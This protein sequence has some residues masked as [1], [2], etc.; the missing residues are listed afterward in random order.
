MTW[1]LSG[2]LGALVLFSVLL[3]MRV[4]CV[5]S[6]AVRAPFPKPV[7]LKALEAR[8]WITLWWAPPA[9]Q[10]PSAPPLPAGRPAD[11]RLRPNVQR[12]GQRQREK[13]VDAQPLDRVDQISRFEVFLVRLDNPRERVVPVRLPIE[14]QSHTFMPL[15]DRSLLLICTNE[16]LY[17]PLI[18]RLIVLYGTAVKNKRYAVSVRMC[19]ETECGEN[20]TDVLATTNTSKSRDSG[21][22]SADYESGGATSGGSSD[23]RL[24]ISKWNHHL[25][26]YTSNNESVTGHSVLISW[27][28]S[29]A[30]SEQP[31]DRFY[32][33]RYVVRVPE[34]PDKTS[35]SGTCLCVS[36]IS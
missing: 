9:I 32:T 12:D 15:G 13:N 7:L 26:Q 6:T 27:K 16:N 2:P 34:P 28:D 17:C 36:L 22:Q 31:G 18:A 14:Q 21:G 19:S 30:A 11:P 8:T 24:G 5:R 4:G 25:C 1:R 3:L 10:Q 35:V 33:A 29:S 23:A 20:A